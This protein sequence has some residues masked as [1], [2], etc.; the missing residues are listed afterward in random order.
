M[1]LRARDRSLEHRE[2]M[3]KSDVLE[4]EALTVFEQQTP[5]KNELA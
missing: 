3:T 2:L 1:D 5:E 4:R